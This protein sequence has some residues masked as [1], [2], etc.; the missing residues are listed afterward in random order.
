[1]VPRYVRHRMEDTNM[2][3]Q[4]GTYY[5]VLRRQSPPWDPALNM[6]EQDGWDA[7]AEF[8][9]ALV[10][11][12]F[13]VLGGPLDGGPRVLLICAAEGEQAIRDRLA[14]DPW[15]ESGMLEIQSVEPWEVLLKAPGSP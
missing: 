10:A 6:R 9:E 13:V 5:V 1:M 12:G 11:D 4:P 14:A 3:S 15:A 2:C 7:H 8:M